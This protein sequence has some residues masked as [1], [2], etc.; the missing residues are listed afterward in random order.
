MSAPSEAED[1]CKSF[2][3]LF[4]GLLSQINDKDISGMCMGVKEGELDEISISIGLD[5]WMNRHGII[6]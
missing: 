5:V 6:L 4:V 2:A 1:L 3:L